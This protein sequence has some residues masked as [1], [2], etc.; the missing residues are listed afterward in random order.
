MLKVTVAIA[1]YNNAKYVDRCMESV[2]N[3]SYT[4]LE[5]LII[6]DG[7]LDDSFTVCKKY[8]ADSRVS[9]IRQ[10]N[11]GLSSVRQ[12]ALS[13][14]SGKYICFIDADDYLAPDYVKT[15]M[16]QLELS[17]ADVCICSTL[18]VDYEGNILKAETNTFTYKDDV[19]PFKLSHEKYS[20]TAVDYKN[21]L[22]LSDSWNKMYRLSFLRKTG[23]AFILPKGYNGTDAIFNQKL[24]YFEPTYVSSSYQGYI[25]VMYKQSATHRKNKKMQ[26]GFQIQMVQQIDTCNHLGITN[27]MR[28]RLVE[29]YY[30]YLLRSFEDVYLEN[31]T[32]KNLRMILVSMRVKHRHF[33]SLHKELNN[34]VPYDCSYKI[35]YYILKYAFFLIKP[36]LSHRLRLN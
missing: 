31:Y 27:L 11:N 15:M 33:V 6:D 5:I 9:L 10:S 17:S 3:Q 21:R 4:D 12:K 20:D 14:S 1:L 26:E 32:S 22:S 24:A 28:K 16:H 25:H 36:F 13:L 30:T 34:V 18:F 19:I 2:L 29:Y 7:S 35:F 23:I 8:L